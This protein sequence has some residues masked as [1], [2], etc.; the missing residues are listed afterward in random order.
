MLQEGFFFAHSNMIFLS[1][2]NN[3]HTVVWF[4]VFLFNYMVSIYYFYLIWF[5]VTNNYNGNYNYD[6]N[7]K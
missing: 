2:T 6:N 5:E 3:L 7:P 4:Q 1:N